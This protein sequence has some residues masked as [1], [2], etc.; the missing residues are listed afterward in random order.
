M[1]DKH[2]RTSTTMLTSA[3]NDALVID[4]PTLIEIC[5]IIQV[6]FF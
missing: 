4:Q 1:I 6:S 3:L 5:M 2:E